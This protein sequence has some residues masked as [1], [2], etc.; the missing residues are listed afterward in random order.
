MKK[1][2]FLLFI[3]ALILSGCYKDNKY[4]VTKP[5]NLIPENKLAS[6]IKE[7]DIV[8]GIISYNRTHRVHDPS[9]EERYYAILFKHYEVTAEQV[10][11][12]MAWYISE[13]KPMAKIYDKVLEQFSI[14]ESLLYEEE[15]ARQ[16]NR[17]DSAGIYKLQFKQ[18]WIYN[19]VD[20]AIPYS[21][22]PVF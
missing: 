5:A 6:I 22:K 18:H 2:I 3:M 20:S 19:V 11:Q 14:D 13:G 17:I 12:S 1:T 4:T 9:A 16:S 15:T 21:F 7:M 8:Q 10:R